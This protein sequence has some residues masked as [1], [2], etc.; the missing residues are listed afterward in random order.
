[1]WSKLGQIQTWHKARRMPQISKL[2]C[3][4]L[5]KSALFAPRLSRS[6]LLPICNYNSSGGAPSRRGFWVNQWATSGCQVS[7]MTIPVQLKPINQVWWLNYCWNKYV[8]CNVI[9]HKHL[10]PKYQGSYPEKKGEFSL[11]LNKGTLSLYDQRPEIGSECVFTGFCAGDAKH[12]L[13]TPRSQSRGPRVLA[14]S[15]LNAAAGQPLL[16]LSNF[17][18]VYLERRSHNQLPCRPRNQSCSCGV[19]FWTWSLESPE[20][21]RCIVAERVLT[22]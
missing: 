14:T 13:P 22:A 2:G 17:P 7:P 19:P 9:H 3:S 15:P 6:H 21:V 5:H 16:S 11:S 10:L 20:W 18:A 1:M 8:N 12:F 4:L